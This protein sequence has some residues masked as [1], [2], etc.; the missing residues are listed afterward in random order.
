VDPS[1]IVR[2]RLVA[3]LAGVEQVA[4]IGQAERATQAIVAMCSDRSS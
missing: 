4:V 1:E 3:L 2:R